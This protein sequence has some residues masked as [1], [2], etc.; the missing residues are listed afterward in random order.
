MAETCDEAK[1]DGL[2]VNEDDR[3]RASRRLGRQRGFGAATRDDL[4]AHLSQPKAIEKMV[5]R[6]EATT[7]RPSIT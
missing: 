6:A 3:S 2:A 5:T 4:L 7:F 1:F